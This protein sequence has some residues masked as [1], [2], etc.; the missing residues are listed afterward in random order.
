MRRCAYVSL[1]GLNSLAELRSAVV[2]N[3]IVA[4]GALVSPDAATLWT[5]WRRAWGRTSPTSPVN[6][7]GTVRFLVATGAM[8]RR[9]I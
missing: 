1:Y 8:V 9:P 3:T 7:D 6:M 4:E 5:Q 2:E